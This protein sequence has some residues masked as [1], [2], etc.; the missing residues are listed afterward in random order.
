MLSLKSV[1]DSIIEFFFFLSVIFQQQSVMYKEFW[2]VQWQLNL[3]IRESGKSHTLFLHTRI[4]VN[5]K[6]AYAKAMGLSTGYVYVLRENPNKN[7]VSTFGF[8]NR[9]RTKTV[10]ST[11][12]TIRPHC[13]M[14]QKPQLWYSPWYGKMSPW[15]SQKYTNMKIT[16]AECTVICY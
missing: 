10:Q 6:T 8:N 14:Y 5:V 12:K 2:R 11:I 1:K 4:K 9:K 16:T 13:Y 3:G 7:R 15:H